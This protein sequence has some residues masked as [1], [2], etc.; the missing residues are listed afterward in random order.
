VNENLMVEDFGGDVQVV[1][2]AG[3]TGE[4]LKDLMDSLLLQADMMDLK[5]ARTGRAE[6]VVLD[7]HVVKGKGVVADV[8]VRWGQLA[9][10]DAI[11]VGNSYGKVKAMLNERGEQQQIAYPS[12]SVRLL[13]LRSLPSTGQELLSVETEDVAKEIADRRQAELD[14]RKAREALLA[15][16]RAANRDRIVAAEAAALALMSKGKGASSADAKGAAAAAA[17]A[18]SAASSDEASAVASGKII[19]HVVIK[20]DGVCTL[21]ALRQIVKGIASRASSDVHVEIVG[22]S[23][24]DVNLSDIE[25]A[26]SGGEPL[27]LAFNVGIAD[28][29]T[30]SMAK[31]RDV[32]I[33][34]DDVIYRLE[35]ELVKT[36]VSYLPKERTLVKEVNV[37]CSVYFLYLYGCV[38]VQL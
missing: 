7:A 19:V 32:T 31:Q 6:V 21:E 14:A 3:K 8:L 36:M 2:V 17:S 13:G 1:E 23:I 18:A 38:C 25:L 11:V 15:A 28:A 12:D 29:A 24:G 9:V 5:A 37:L 35:E 27:V 34:R 33:C 16:K 22:S 20:A 10:G 26:T 4:G 30:R